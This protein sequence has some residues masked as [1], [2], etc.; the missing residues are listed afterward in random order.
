MTNKTFKDEVIAEFDKDFPPM[1]GLFNTESGWA[2]RCDP[3]EIKQFITSSLDLQKKKILEALPT[4][5]N[6]ETS[7]YQHGFDK[8]IGEVKKIIEN[9]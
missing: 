4:E 2:I 3:K 8:C 9:I 6:G 5:I 7:D 1:Q